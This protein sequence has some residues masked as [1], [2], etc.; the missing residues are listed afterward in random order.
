MPS[1]PSM[2]YLR[3]AHHTGTGG[4]TPETLASACRSQGRPA[5]AQKGTAMATEIT[6]GTPV[7]GTAGVAS[8]QRHRSLGELVA[9]SI[10]WFA[11]NFHW[12]A[13]PVF[14]VPP[15]IVALLY[16]AAPHTGSLS[17][18]DWTNQ[19]KSLALALVVAPGLIVALIANPYFGLLSDRTPGRFGRR[20]PYILIGT[21]VNVVGLAMMAVLPATLIQDGSGQV[22]SPS[23]L[24]LMAGLMLTQ[25]ANNAAA[26]PFHAL[27]PDLV[28]ADQRGVA[29]GVMGIA[30][31]LGTVG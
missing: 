16:R 4:R 30:Y 31:W 25:L 15:Q 10:Y 17:A 28:P 14:I 3:Q 13:L 23:L 26:A 12:A 24:A 22:I 1:M 7:T 27:L 6:A 8:T 18:T 11:L 21:L 9:I 5:G 2:L 19:Y 20:R 29:S